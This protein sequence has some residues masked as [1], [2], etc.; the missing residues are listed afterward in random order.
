MKTFNER[1]DMNKKMKIPVTF[2]P[3]SDWNTWEQPIIGSRE[4]AREVRPIQKSSQTPIGLM[5]TA[6]MEV[7]SPAPE[8]R[9]GKPAGLPCRVDN[10]DEHAGVTFEIRQQ[11]IATNQEGR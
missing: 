11:I 3:I 7:A 6:H 2:A 4:L 10:Q 5:Q 8:Q 9:W 1:N